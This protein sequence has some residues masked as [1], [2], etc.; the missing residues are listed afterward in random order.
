MFRV[1]QM[2]ALGCIAI[3]LSSCFDILE[4]I[5]FNKD[6]S[7]S[8]TTTLD[9]SGLKEQMKLMSSLDTT[10]N[11]ESGFNYSMDSTYKESI[12]KYKSVS[13]ISNVVGSTAK[14]NEYTITLDFASVDALSRAIYL[15]KNTEDAKNIYSWKKGNFL[16]TNNSLNLVDDGDEEQAEMMKT[17]IAENKY[18]I[19]VNAPGKIKSAGNRNA[20]ISE[21]KKSVKLVTKLTDLL[22][23]KSSLELDIDYK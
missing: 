7:G 10:G 13:G 19:I 4:I 23:A 22:D 2:F 6:G 3:C 8:Y 11:M 20:V 15:D 21:D 14:E 5:S 1:L 9:V 18:T 17:F 12:R 16:R